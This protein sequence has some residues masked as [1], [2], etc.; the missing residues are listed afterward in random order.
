MSRTTRH[1]VAAA[2]ATL[3]LAACATTSG[4]APTGTSPTASPGGSTAASPGGSTAASPGTPATSPSQST[5]APASSPAP[6]PFAY[7]P[8][9][10]FANLAQVRAWQAAFI[11]GGHQPWHLSATGTAL[12]FAAWLG[13]RDMSRV[14]RVTGTTSDAHVAVGFALPNGKTATAAVVHVVRY[15]SGRNVPWEVTGTDDTTLTLDI[16]GY[17][18]VVS[19]PVRIGGKITGV[20]ENLRAEVHSLAAATP[21][22]SYCCSAAGGQRTPWSL[23]VPFRAPSGTVITIAVHTGGHVAA[24]ERFAVT[25]VRVR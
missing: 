8:L 1:C 18:S 19:S 6:A 17:G 2:A 9:Y 21:V 11:S 15:G 23:T 14:A 12:A 22:G 13:F 25:G 20:D 24:V 4:P 7:L 3:L 5:G 10:P 16:P